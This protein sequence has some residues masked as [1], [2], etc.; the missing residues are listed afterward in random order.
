MRAAR[1]RRPWPPR[2]PIRRPSTS[3][4]DGD[5]PGPARPRARRPRARRASRRSASLAVGGA[6]GALRATRRLRRLPARRLD[7]LHGRRARRAA[8]P[9]ACVAP[10]AALGARWQPRRDGSTSWADAFQLSAALVGL[11]M[12]LVLVGVLLHPTR[13]VLMTGR[14]L[15]LPG[16]E[17]DAARERVS[18]E[19]DGALDDVGRGLLARHL[20][21]VRRVLRPSRRS[22]VL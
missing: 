7:R 14:L 19:L 17:C 4:C 9:G 1:R 11:G 12:G 8:R 18:L 6:A 2:I 5:R 22:S 16:R 13:L 15:A 21:T 10:R 3:G 20:A